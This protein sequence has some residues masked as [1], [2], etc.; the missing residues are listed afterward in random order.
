MTQQ[1]PAPSAEA[2]DAILT[3]LALAA[4]ARFRTSE[5]VAVAFLRDAILSGQFR[6]GDRLNQDRIARA[7]GMSRIPVRTALRQLEA[8]RLVTI[9]PFRGS[10]VATRTPDEI[11]EIYD[12]RITVE[13]LALSYVAQSLTPE[14]FARMM[15]EAQHLDAAEVVDEAWIA[16]R[17]RLYDALFTASG[18]ERTIGLVASLRMELA[19]Y[20]AAHQVHRVRVNHAGH[21]EFLTMLH[22]G[23]AAGAIA[24]HRS[25]LLAVRD[26]VLRNVR[27][28]A[29]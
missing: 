23:D 20:I 22:D 7:L 2:G 26:M 3:K 19:G 4:H 5:E 21:V 11:A 8:E 18:R 1:G 25:H 17:D 14:V 28:G 29:A 6:P 9:H 13:C 24:W 15:P 16:A 27:G 10:T 12:L